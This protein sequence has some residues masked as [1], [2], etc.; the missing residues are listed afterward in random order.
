MTDEERANILALRQ[1]GMYSEEEDT[2]AYF[3]N[4]TQARFDRHN[5]GAVVS[6]VA[7]RISKAAFSSE[8]W[9]PN[10]SKRFKE[11]GTGILGFGRRMIENPGVKEGLIVGA[12]FLA[13]MSLWFAYRKASR[14][15]L[16][17]VD[18]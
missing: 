6:E 16:E 15:G 9:A 10:V 2:D 18:L 8:E 17:I 13:K 14:E 3:R 11:A 1:L 5:H 7:R 12:V 4:R